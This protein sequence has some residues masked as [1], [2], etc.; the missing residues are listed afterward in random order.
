MN[1][2]DAKR[3]AE[4]ELHAARERLKLRDRRG[5]VFAVAEMASEVDA[6]AGADPGAVVVRFE[7]TEHTLYHLDTIERLYFWLKSLNTR[8]E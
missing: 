1:P 5:K 3:A 7:G 2:F 8:A 4:R 6:K